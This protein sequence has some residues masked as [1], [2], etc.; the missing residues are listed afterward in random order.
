MPSGRTL[1]NDSGQ[2]AHFGNLVGHLLA[3][4]MAAEADLAALADEE[5]AGI[6]ETQMM[7]VE[8]IARL[9]ALIEPF[10]RIAPLIGDHAAF[11]RAGGRTGHGGATGERDLR[12]IGKRAEGHAGH[13]DLD[14]EHHRTLVVR[15]VDRRGVELYA[16]T[17][18]YVTG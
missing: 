2:R 18:V 10:H 15:A 17:H 8:A 9:D 13:V 16:I 11:A 4:E 3:H 6:G 12:F 5:L 1:V 14:I 7:R